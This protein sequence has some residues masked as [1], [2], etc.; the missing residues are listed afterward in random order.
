MR[1]VRAR[2]AG[3]AG[4]TLVIAGREFNART[5]TRVF[6]I[7]TALAVIGIAGY[8]VLQASVFGKSTSLQVGFV[9]EAQQLSAPVKAEMAHLDITVTTHAVATLAHGQA[10]VRSGA[11]DALV[12]GPPAATTLT[13]QTSANGTL[14]TVLTD[15][16][17][18]EVLNDLLAR[19]GVAAADI[20]RAL[21]ATSVEVHT[22]T[23]PLSAESIQ[24][25]VIGLLV[26]G[27]LYVGL[28]VYGQFVAAG[29]IEEKSN[30]IVELLLTTVR[31]WQLMVGKITGIGMVAL[32]Q[33]A[34]VAAVA[35]VVAAATNLVSIST[36]GVDVVLGG[37]LWLILG[38]LMYALVFAAAGSMVSRQEDVSGVTM[39]VILV[40][41]AAWII[42]LTVVAPS[43]T[44]TA[45]TVLSLIPP[46][47]PMVM[48]VRI[49]VG[50]VPLWQV[51]LSV[52][53]ALATIWLL[54][55]V[56]GRIYRNSVLH[57]GGRVRLG[58]ALGLPGSG[59][60]GSAAASGPHAPPEQFM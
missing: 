7:T 42:T 5:R 43:P 8:I 11:L 30:R 24:E 23:P 1:D 2:V 39:P 26:S 21:A 38:F 4:L 46:M 27:T 32:L 17:R 45:T 28:V 50:D 54:A 6:V 31:P 57:V 37:L 33:I 16:A 29:V 15:F 55:A 20:D 58:E 48:P 53:F 52:V 56:A 25:I 10:E 40:L 35:L 41:V 51:V 13:V 44:S 3:A 59:T 60:P 34:A 12:S 22:L 18:E 14:Q 36:L 19:Q 47:A 49:A 9:G